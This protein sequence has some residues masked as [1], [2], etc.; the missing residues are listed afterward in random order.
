MILY[1]A[2][3]LKNGNCLRPRQGKIDQATVFNENAI[4]Q[5]REFIEQVC[6]WLSVI[7]LDAAISHPN[8][9]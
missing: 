2:I 1:P 4:E 8:I 3:D 7:D 6:K 9:N 5:A